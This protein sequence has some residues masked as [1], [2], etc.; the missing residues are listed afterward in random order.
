MPL[1][2]PMVFDLAEYQEQQAVIAALKATE[3]AESEQ[4][5]DASTST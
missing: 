2:D 5:G 4:S 3:A 1:K